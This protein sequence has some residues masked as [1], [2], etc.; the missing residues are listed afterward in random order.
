VNKKKIS[1]KERKG[2]IRSKEFS[3]FSA[4]SYIA[5]REP[6]L[7]LSLKGRKG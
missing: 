3:A 2:E 5:L 7:K 6:L 4:S 1:R